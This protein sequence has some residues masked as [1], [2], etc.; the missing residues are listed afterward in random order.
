MATHILLAIK[1]MWK[2]A[3]LAT[4]LKFIEVIFISAMTPLSL[5]FTQNLINGF[6]SYFNLETNVS[7]IVLCS[8][9]LI[10]SMFLASSQGFINEMQSINMKRK[11][12]E[13]FTQHVVEK[14]RR[15]EF[16]C[17]ENTKIQDTL[18]R[19][20]NSPQDL[21]LNTFQDCMSALSTFISIVGIILIFAQVSWFLPML[22]FLIIPFIVFLVI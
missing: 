4:F 16:A 14:Y 19:M 13:R 3:R 10:L 1:M 2:Y 6:V 17:F 22:F 9:L 21:I 18:S 8:V 7:S 15:I 20:G 11:L 5:L 12:D